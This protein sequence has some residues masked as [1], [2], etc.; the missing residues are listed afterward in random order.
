MSKQIFPSTEQVLDILLGELPGGVYAED[1]ADDPDLDLRSYSSSELRAHAEIFANLYQNLFDINRD[2][3]ISTITPDALNAWEKDLFSEAQDASQTFEYR[4]Q[5]LLSKKRTQGSI[6][7]PNINSIVSG[8]LG[9]LGIP[10]EILPYS[11]QSNGVNTGA[12]LLELSGLDVGTYLA[13][14]D[15]I[16]GALVGYTPLDCNLDYAAAGITLAQMQA[17]QATAYTYEL[18]I[19]G[20][21]SADILDLLDKNLTQYEP[22]RSTHVIRNNAQLPIGPFALDLGSFVGT[23]INAYDCGT[24]QMPPATYDVFDC[25]GF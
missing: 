4:K 3:F 9:P 8:I 1:R 18:R 11:G 13:D 12:W 7:L 24:F 10:F 22:A 25:G 20:N 16:W 19:Y 2:K 6:A 14:I 21:V 5:N 17:I 15:P 23:M